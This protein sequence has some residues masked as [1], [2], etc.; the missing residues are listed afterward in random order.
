MRA[1]NRSL[2]VDIRLLP[3]DL[4]VN[5][6]WA[7]ELCRIGVYD[8][9]G[10][11]AVVGELDAIGRRFRE[12]EFDVLPP[13]EDVHTLVERLL[14]EALGPIG[15]A[16]H[17]GRSRNDQVMCDTHLFLMEALDALS[18]A[19]AELAATLA[20]IAREHAGTVM[21]GMTHMQAAQPISLGYFLV[22]LAFALVR[23]RERMIDARGRASRC[24]LGSGALAGS[25]FDVDRFALASALGFDDV[26]ENG[27]DA[28]GDRDA[29]QETAGA[30]AILAAHLSRYAE[31]FIIWSSAP[32]GFV[33][34]SDEWATGSSMMPQK[35]NPDAME[36]IRGRASRIIGNASSL[37]ILTKGVPP[38]Y[39]K[40]LQDDKS[41]IFQTIDDT[42]LIL[43]VFRGAVSSAS[44]LTDRMA[45]ALTAD[46]LATDIADSLSR[47]GVP[48]RTAHERTARYV[49]LAEETGFDILCVPDETFRQAFPELPGKAGFT[50]ENA[51]Q[52]R[53]VFG[54]TAPGRVLEQ[55]ESIRKHLDAA[56]SA[57]RAKKSPL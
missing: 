22:S 37:M 21:P 40:D 56:G 11:N 57:G 10:L 25:G 2:P 53:R 54:G 32:F 15:G 3:Q 55:C 6:A 45:A 46:L 18:D 47:T 26:C 8:Q 5:A 35:R 28:T 9:A 19:V 13:D 52:N 12:G 43:E 49:T 20:G 24:P 33:R 27:L 4:A 34:F 50:Y 39:A 41:L 48:F 1:L 42:M 17:T 31:Q 14:T 38:A 23:D 44:F 7:V 16:I 51:L 30:C 29:V 36:L